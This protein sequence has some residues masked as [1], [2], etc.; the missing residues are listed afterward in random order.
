MLLAST[1]GIF[2]LDRIILAIFVPKVFY[3][4]TIK[5]LLSTKPRDF[6]PLLKTMVYVSGNNDGIYS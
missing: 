6:I 5:P 2:L 1:V 4:S 3:A